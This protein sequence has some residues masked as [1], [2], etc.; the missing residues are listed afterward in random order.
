MQG[1]LSRRLPHEDIQETVLWMTIYH[2]DSGPVEGFD[3]YDGVFL[4]SPLL[5]ATF[6][7][8]VIDRVDVV[9]QR[10]GHEVGN[11]RRHWLWFVVFPVH[12]NPRTQNWL[13][14]CFRT[15]ALHI[16]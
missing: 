9:D 11:G 14:L 16:I 4:G 13:D 8:V 10:L 15:F 7:W 3:P 1:F 12:D 6:N 5:E 2:S